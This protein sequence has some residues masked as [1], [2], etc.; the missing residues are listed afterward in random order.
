MSLDDLNAFVAILLAIGLAGERFVTFLKNL[1]PGLLADQPR[2]DTG[3]PRTSSEKWRRVVVQFIGFLACW[4]VAS[5]LTADGKMDMLGHFKWSENS[6]LPIWVVGMLASSGSAM[7]A[8]VLGITSAAKD[9]RK[10]AVV[11]SGIDLKGQIAA[12]GGPP[13]FDVSRESLRGL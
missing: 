9:L 6:K 1:A 3:H 10:Q 4:L 7:W 13:P 5:F 8:S 11:A 12:A 2:D